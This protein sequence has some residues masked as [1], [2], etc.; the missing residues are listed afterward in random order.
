MNFMNYI[1]NLFVKDYQEFDYYAV[2]TP[3]EPPM[4][5]MTRK[6]AHKYMDNY[7]AQNPH[8]ARYVLFYGYNQ[9]DLDDF[10]K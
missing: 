2:F 6:A 10:T 3:T 9:K 8:H 4:K 7:L 5:F 1:K